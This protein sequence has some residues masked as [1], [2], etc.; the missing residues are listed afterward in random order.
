MDHSHEE[1]TFMVN[2]AAMQ[3]KFAN[4]FDEFEQKYKKVTEES[5]ISVE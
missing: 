2:P 4:A 5:K 3:T 1:N